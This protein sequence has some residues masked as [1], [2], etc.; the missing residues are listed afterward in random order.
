MPDTG[1]PRGAM[2]LREHEIHHLRTMAYL[3]GHADELGVSAN[4]VGFEVRESASTD[5]IELRLIAPAGAF[6]RLFDDLDR[7]RGDSSTRSGPKGRSS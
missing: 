6:R 7:H 4:A 5:R 3:I 1:L 2:A